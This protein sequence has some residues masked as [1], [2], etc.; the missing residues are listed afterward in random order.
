ME[1]S[2]FL[3]LSDGLHIEGVTA[4]ANELLVHVVSQSPRACCPRCGVQASRIHSRYTRHIADL[5]C[6]GRH[7]T[8]VLT[9]RKFFCPN[10]ACPRSIFAEQ[11]PDLVPSYARLTNR[12]REAL[13]SLGLATCGEVASRLAP[14]LGMQVAPTTLLRRVRAVPVARAGRVRVL[15]VDDF[16]W[17]KGQTYGTI[18]VDLELHRPIELLPDRAEETLEAWLRTHPEVEVVSR[19]R[20]G[21]YA[22]AARKGAPQAQQIADRFHLLRNL[23]EGLKDLMDRKQSSLPEVAEH[24]SDAIEASAQGL[25]NKSVQPQAEPQAEPAPE[26]HYRTIPPYPYQ[27]PAG[28]S[29]NEFRKQVRRDKRSV[30]YDNVRTLFEQGLSQRAIARKL[31]LS[32][33]TVSKFVQAEQ[34]PEM[35]HPKRGEKRSLLDPH[36]PYIL[37]RWQQGCRNSVQ[38]Y[39]EITAR[40]FAG[41]ASLL[42]VFLADLRKKHREAGKASVLTLDASTQAIKIPASLPPKPQ[43][44]CRM[45]PTRASWLFVSRPEKLDEK[46]R[47]L[48]EHIRKGHRDLETAY[49]LSQGFVTML[50]ERRDKDLDTWLTQAEGSGLPEFKKL[51]NG[52]RH[53][54]AAVRAAFSSQWSNGQVEA[55][56]NCLKL[57]KRQMFGRAKFDLLRLRVLHAV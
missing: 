38:L 48:V 9:V 6:A 53:D 55:Q 40:G 20:A 26:K 30:R 10:P 56:V 24:A 33:A 29:Y 57:Q 15:G 22:A 45:S 28:M 5:P 43:I 50:A 7:V 34:Y 37:Q 52:I 8:L 13:V 41:S 35:H 3:P 12:L 32:R 49:Q 16:A 47:K 31:K 17:K 42:R 14:R 21:N 23:R 44:I 27:R 4:S 46:Q 19:D 51:A 18:L 1:V 39:D 36:K 25:K 54:Y 2:P 11:F